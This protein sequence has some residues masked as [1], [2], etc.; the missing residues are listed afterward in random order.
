MNDPETSRPEVDVSLSAPDTSG[1]AGIRRRWAARV[2]GA[3]FLAAPMVLA[4]GGTADAG[5]LDP[6]LEDPTEVV[7]EVVDPVLEEGTEVVSEV[8]DPVLEETTEVV[9]E[10]VDPVLEE[11]TE[12]VSEVVDPVLE[13]TT[14]V[15]SEVVDPVLGV[16]DALVSETTETVGE[17]DAGPVFPHPPPDPSFEGTFP[18]P[19][20]RSASAVDL[21]RGA[22]LVDRPAPFDALRHVSSSTTVMT[23]AFSGAA[24]AQRAHALDG[25]AP[26]SSPRAPVGRSEAVTTATL[27][28]LLAGLTASVRLFLPSVRSA[29][30]WREVPWKAATFALSVERPG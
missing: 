10:V 7:S 27:L 17:I 9:S 23:P 1:Q 19:G 8:V 6:A 16:V 13:E 12:V 4:L 11:T 14:E 28:L 2:V 24:A 3:A 30:A 5:E 25:H 22:R 18:V 26:T 15:V 29:L 20:A 21:F